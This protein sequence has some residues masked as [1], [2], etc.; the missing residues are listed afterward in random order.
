MNGIGRLKIVG[1]DSNIFIYQFED[2]PD[3]IKFTDLI[4]KDLANNKKKAVTSIISVIEA[5]S[6][7]S[8]P[9]VLESI[10]DAFQSFP[11]LK[12]FGIDN[13]IA[14]DTARIRREYKYRLPDAV[15]LA[16]AIQGRA[17]AFITNDNRLKKFKELKIVLLKEI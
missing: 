17:Q 2:N 6:Y 14:K 10:E 13:E 5:L 15:Q 1:L 4:F 9:N 7:P 12:I 16:T 3:F 8:L 11:N